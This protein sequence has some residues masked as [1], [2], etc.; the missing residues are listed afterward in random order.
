MTAR[1]DSF[2]K[3]TVPTLHRGAEG[4][5]RPVSEAQS[6]AQKK[7]RDERAAAASAAATR[8]KAIDEA[9]GIDAWVKAE[10]QK[11]GLGSDGQDP[12][13][14]SDREKG[15]YKARKKAEAEARKALKAQA[16]AAYR[17]T[18]IGHLGAGVYWTDDEGETDKLDIAH[19]AERARDNGLPDLRGASDLAQAL[20]KV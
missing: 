17:A 8:W 18:H 19:R 7:A 16:Y 20:D 14:M 2:V 13:T 10:L 4:A 15:Q 1:I 3:A 5:P 12:S 9:G 11:Q 6:A